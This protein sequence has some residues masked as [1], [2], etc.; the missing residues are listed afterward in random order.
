MVT[1]RGGGWAGRVRV[2]VRPRW[3]ARRIYL[4]GD[5]KTGIVA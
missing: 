1:A 4:A 3:A 2:G 5:E